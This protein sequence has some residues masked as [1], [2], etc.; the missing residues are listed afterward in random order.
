MYHR[1]LGE[2]RYTMG[3]HEN[4]ELAKSYYEHAAKLNTRDLR[5]QYGIVL[6]CLL[7]FL[8]NLVH[9]SAQI[10]W[11][12]QKHQ[13]KRR[14]SM[15]LTVKQLQLEFCRCMTRYIYYQFLCCHNTFKLNFIGEISIC[16]NRHVR[17][18]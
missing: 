2:L 17:L 16:F 18:Y 11:L 14:K 10:I 6:V 3:G 9:F 7:F 13:L 5:A 12:R 15:L 1:R 4:V 8:L